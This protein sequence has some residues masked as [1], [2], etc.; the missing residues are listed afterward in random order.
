M[1]ISSTMIATA[2]TT[3]EVTGMDQEVA[4]TTTTDVHHEAHRRA[5]MM[6]TDLHQDQVLEDILEARI[7]MAIVTVV[8]R[9]AGSTQGMRMLRPHMEGEEV[10]A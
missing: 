9:Q 10:A 2:T 4:T 6:V 3:R 8:H 1:L 5:E 7:Q